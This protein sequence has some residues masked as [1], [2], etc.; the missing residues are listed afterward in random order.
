MSMNYENLFELV[1]SRLVVLKI[2]KKQRTKTKPNFLN[3]N[4]RSEGT[5]KTCVTYHYRI[6]NVLI[7]LS[8]V[9]SWG[10]NALK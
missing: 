6:I 1:T 9:K 8:P 10:L 4:N 5:K 7:T 3:F 2:K